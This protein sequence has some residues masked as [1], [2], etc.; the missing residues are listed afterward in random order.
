MQLQF[1]FLNFKCN[2]F[3]IAGNKCSIRSVMLHVRG[4]LL[5]NITVIARFVF[6][7]LHYCICNYTF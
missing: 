4:E 6:Q 5:Y 3:H 7:Q 2:W 1:I